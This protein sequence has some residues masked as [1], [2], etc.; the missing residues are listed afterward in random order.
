MKKAVVA[1]GTGFMGNALVHW[2]A[3]K[4]WEV[5]VLTRQQRAAEPGIRYVHWDARTTGP[6]EAE[7][8]SSQ[9]LINLCGRTVDC[10]YNAKNRAEIYA[11]RLD[12]TRAL[13]EA[14]DRCTGKPAVWLNAAS[15]TIYR[16]AED[17]RQDEATGEYG[18]GFSVDVCKQWEAA[19]FSNSTLGIRQVA[20]RTAIVIGEGGGVMKPLSR[21]VKTGL[22]GKMGS[23]KQMF[24]WI[25]IH[26]FCRAVEFIIA[27]D[28]LE[29]PVNLSAPGAV[30]NESCMQNLRQKAGIPFGL[31]LSEPLLELGAR[32]LRTETELVL[33]SRWVWPGRLLDAG[34]EFQYGNIQT[35][36]G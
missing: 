19:F 13:G 5:T 4:G 22:G 28:A 31:P 15:A 3:E 17:R 33:K 16:H 14:L 2:L 23:G 34:F 18:S 36:M 12:S 29:G 30:T 20:L 26:D 8:E 9:V 35:L 7:L 10:R 32:L 6:W 21:L 25:H 24:S 11:S 1:G 27:N